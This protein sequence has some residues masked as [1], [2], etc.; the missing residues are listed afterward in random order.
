MYKEHDETKM[1]MDSCR[2]RMGLLALLLLL[3]AGGGG[4]GGGRVLR[5]DP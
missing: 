2:L 5:A 4:G 3:M 1:K